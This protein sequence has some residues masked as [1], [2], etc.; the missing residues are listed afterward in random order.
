L[1]PLGLE[2]E[3]E[4]F[5]VVGGTFGSAHTTT[6]SP[7]FETAVTVMRA[8][9]MFRNLHGGWDT[10]EWRVLAAHVCGGFNGSLHRFGEFV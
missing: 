1:F 9:C 10:L 5:A 2:G 7:S 6:L 8:I 3:T 4:R